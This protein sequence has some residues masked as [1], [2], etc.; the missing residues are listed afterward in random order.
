[1]PPSLSL[2]V[3]LR[4]P[5]V[6]LSSREIGD[7]RERTSALCDLSAQWAARFVDIDRSILC[8]SSVKFKMSSCD[9]LTGLTF[10][11]SIVMCSGTR[12]RTR[13]SRN[14][15]ALTI[16]AALRTLE[17][18]HDIIYAVPQSARANFQSAMKIRDIKGHGPDD[19]KV[20]TCS[21]GL[22]L[23]SP[24]RDASLQVETVFNSAVRSRQG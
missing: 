13:R 22:S 18:T 7:A 9:T 20:S 5:R 4:K 16:I 2:T 10:R 11:V 12:V 23:N 6:Y 17:R 14:S 15:N 1:M 24:I 8:Y 21:I 19:K 3:C